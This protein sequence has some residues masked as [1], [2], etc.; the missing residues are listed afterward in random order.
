MAATVQ[1]VPFRNVTMLFVGAV[2]GPSKQEQVTVLLDTGSSHNVCS[3]SV[4]KLNNSGTGRSFS[5]ACAGTEHR[6]NASENLYKLT[7]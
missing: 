4:S 1:A 5:V 3:P 6:V 7:V 2:Q